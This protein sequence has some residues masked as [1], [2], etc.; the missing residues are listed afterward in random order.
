VYSYSLPWSVHCVATNSSLTCWMS[1]NKA[2]S[3]CRLAMYNSLWLWVVTLS[4]VIYLVYNMYKMYYKSDIHYTIKSTSG[5]GKFALKYWD[6][7]SITPQTFR[8]WPSLLRFSKE[9]A[10]FFV[11]T[12]PHARYV[13][14]PNQFLSTHIATIGQEIQLRNS[15][16]YR[17]FFV[18]WMSYIRVKDALNSMGTSCAL[19]TPRVLSACSPVRRT[20][21][22]IRHVIL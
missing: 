15:L 17:F 5:R 7:K 8:K 14:R 9:N 10:L 19:V 2:N 12:F 11:T 13:C 3:N 16:L 6:N 4:S 20:T 22:R 1:Y 21:W 18:F